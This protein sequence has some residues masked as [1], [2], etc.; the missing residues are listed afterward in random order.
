MFHARLLVTGAG[1][2]VT[3]ETFVETN[4]LLTLLGRLCYLGNEK[5]I[6]VTCNQVI[7]KPIFDTVSTSPQCSLWYQQNILY[8]GLVKSAFD[9]FGKVTS[10]RLTVTPSAISGQQ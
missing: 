6:I 1:H 5:Y 10:Q 4:I 3:V 2:H 8:R 9:M 7:N